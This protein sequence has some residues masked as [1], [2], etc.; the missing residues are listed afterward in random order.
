MTL[1]TE[2][3]REKLIK[4]GLDVEKGANEFDLQPPVKLFN[5]CGAGTWLLSFIYPDEPNLAFGLADLGQG[6]PE[7]G[8]IYLPELEQFRGKFGLGIERDLHFTPSKS[9]RKYAD[10]AHEKGSLIA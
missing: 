1:L 3:L 4:I 9:L 5:P 8:D 2:E 10:E 7:T 6:F